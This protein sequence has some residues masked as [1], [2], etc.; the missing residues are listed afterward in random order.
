MEKKGYSF[1]NAHL[2]HLNLHMLGH[3]NQLET[4]EQSSQHSLWNI[5]K[6]E[7]QR[8]NTALQLF[9]YLIV[10]QGGGEQMG[11]GV[12]VRYGQVE[13]VVTVWEGNGTGNGTVWPKS[14]PNL[15]ETQRFQIAVHLQREVF[16]LDQIILIQTFHTIVVVVV[17][18]IVVE[19]IQ[20]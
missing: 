1:Y 2:S 4:S 6:V 8:P 10:H 13:F 16:K 5:G 11:S 9:W 3:L 19:R 12:I 20:R 15:P 14:P 7:V 18:E 17:V